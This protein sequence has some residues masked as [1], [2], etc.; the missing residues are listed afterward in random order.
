[1]L[2]VLVVDDDYSQ[3]EY[4]KN[5]ID[6]QQE[7][8]H[9]CGEADNGNS[10][11]E[12]IQ[13]LHPDLL[14]LDI[15]M[16][17]MDGLMLSQKLYLLSSPIKTIIVSGYDEFEYA[18]KAMMYG[19]QYYI[20]KPLDK[21]ELMEAIQKIRFTITNETNNKLKMN[22]LYDKL[23]QSLPLLRNQFLSNLIL[24]KIN[25][26]PKHFWEKIRYLEIPLKHVLYCSAVIE[27]DE[28][29]SSFRSKEDSIIICSKIREICDKNVP[30]NCSHVVF[31]DTFNRIVIILEATEG[32]KK[33]TIK[34]LQM[35]HECIYH[36]L[37]ISTTISCG[38]SYSLI[39]IFESYNEAMKCLKTKSYSGN[40]QVLDYNVIEIEE[41]KFIPL[42]D[43]FRDRIHIY[44]HQKN[45]E[46]LKTEIRDIL[47]SYKATK[48][49]ME[50]MR[51]LALEILNIGFHYIGVNKF[52]I[53]QVLG[54]DYE[55]M[56][57]LHSLS[58]YEDF[59]VYLEQFFIKIIMFFK[60]L[61]RPI[62]S[63]L[64]V[65]AK[66][67]ID[68]NYSLRDLSLE[69][70]A[71]E[72]YVHP[73]YLSSTFKKELGKTITEYIIGIRMKHALELLESGNRMSIADLATAVGYED[74]YYFSKVFKKYY[75]YTPNQCL[76]D[77]R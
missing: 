45:V 47:T 24:N 68:R 20:L 34:Y 75:G 76:R 69:N 10:A 63:E 57:E 14:I 1:M 23:N 39:N 18:K 4:I 19:V 33:E 50:Y 32:Y 56:K 2:N 13:E 70:I 74:H 66:N 26:E 55:P 30:N 37:A 77:I 36:H 31:N 11:L 17:V 9:I 44:I 7:N 25:Y 65:K 35:I 61:D 38:C 59:E 67:F 5:I 71:S 3:R 60:K 8:F 53:S 64:I 51:I 43:K 21:T 58:S 42:A 48:T 62:I 12:L 73:V 72:L 16:P 28:T 27:I 41:E 54:S 40:N 52:S 46:A 49:T 6:W 22:I 29:L 15:N